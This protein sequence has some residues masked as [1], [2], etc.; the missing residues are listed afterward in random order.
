[1]RLPSNITLPPVRRPPLNGSRPV[2]VRSMVVLPAPFGPSRTT[3]S[4]GWTAILT[5]FSASMAPPR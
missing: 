1:M 5:S 4:A 3:I 2:I